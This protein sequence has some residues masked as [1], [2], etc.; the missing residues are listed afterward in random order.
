MTF[1]NIKDIDNKEDLITYYLDN[2][3]NNLKI[4][5]CELILTKIGEEDFN[6]PVKLSSKQKNNIINIVNDDSKNDNHKFEECLNILSFDQ[7][8]YIGW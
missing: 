6:S 4:S 8:N 3:K 5:F 2:Y 7:I 1:N